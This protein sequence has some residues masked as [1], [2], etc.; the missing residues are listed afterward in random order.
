MDAG[1]NH[2]FSVTINNEDHVGI[3]VGL[4]E[5]PEDAKRLRRFFQGKLPGALHFV[6][7][8][9][10]NGHVFDSGP[11]GD[12]VTPTTFGP[13]LVGDTITLV[14]E[15]TA[16]STTGGAE[17]PSAT[18]LTLIV[19]RGSTDTEVQTF[20]Y[21]L[22]GSVLGINKLFPAVRFH[23]EAY[24]ES[25][26]SETGSESSGGGASGIVIDEASDTATSAGQGHQDV[27]PPVPKAAS[28]GGARSLAK[29]VTTGLFARRSSHASVFLSYQPQLASNHESIHG[30]FRVIFN[31]IKNSYDHM[32]EHG[33][34]GGQAY[35]WLRN[36]ADHAMDCANN[37]VNA[38]RFVHFVRDK[39]NPQ[40]RSLLNSRKIKN[41]M[42]GTGDA[43]LAEEESFLLDILEPLLVEYLSIDS[44]LGKSYFFERIADRYHFF[45]RLG[46]GF[47]DTNSKVETLWA[48]VETH[49]EILRSTMSVD[50]FPVVVQC[51]ERLISLAKSDLGILEELQ[52]MRFFYGKNGLALRIVLNKRAERLNRVVT[53][54]W[55]SAGDAEGFTQELQGRITAAG[56]FHPKRRAGV[57]GCL[58]R[59]KRLAGTDINAWDGTHF[60]QPKEPKSHDN[61]AAASVETFSKVVPSGNTSGNIPS[62]RNKD[63]PADATA[64]GMHPDTSHTSSSHAYDQQKSHTDFVSNLMRIDSG[65]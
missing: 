9:C 35:Y 31:T 23:Q 51:L 54:G 20:T 42:C 36:A 15:T 34:L 59:A 39:H 27:A 62:E 65:H 33:L 45:S 21:T 38:K 30:M 17:T 7:L 28:A 58:R 50:K 41:A 57:F 43:S 22:G 52:P 64:G 11:H 49:S 3:T 2:S 40:I 6:G 48:F 1:G 5:R 53:Q 26:M 16:D 24:H 61:Q 18:R 19:N 14:T 25:S 44:V 32:F 63:H 37:E 12:T 56:R 60:D 13:V 46:Y 8:N 47:A 55:L 10:A 4:L 29:Q